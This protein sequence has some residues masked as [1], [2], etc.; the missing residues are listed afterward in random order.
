MSTK[1]TINILGAI[2]GISGSI[3]VAYEVS[4][5]LMIGIL[6]MLWGNNCQQRN[7]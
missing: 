1:L 4:P 6:L 3:L 2:L 5:L 7:Q